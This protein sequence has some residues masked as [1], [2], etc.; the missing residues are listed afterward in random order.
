[1]KKRLTNRV[2]YIRSHYIATVKELCEY[3]LHLWSVWWQEQGTRFLFTK[4]HLILK[5]AQT[6]Y[7]PISIHFH[8]GFKSR[9]RSV[10]S[11]TQVTQKAGLSHSD[12]ILCRSCQFR[13]VWQCAKH[14]VS[15][16][17]AIE[18]LQRG[19]L[20]RPFF[21]YW[22]SLFTIQRCFS[23]QTSSAAVQ[24]PPPHKHTTHVQN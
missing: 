8:I 12:D 10:S 5:V 20:Q 9:T 18:L 6:C 2:L 7:F 1:M 15:W 23:H 4:T 17:L 16:L 21:L 19:F 24:S 14:P 11:H 13:A 22:C 3:F